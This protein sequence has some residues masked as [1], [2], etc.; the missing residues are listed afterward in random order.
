MPD[1]QMKL[2]IDE[3]QDVPVPQEVS[4]IFNGTQDPNDSMSELDEQMDLPDEMEKVETLQSV[5]H[6]QLKASTIRKQW[7]T[8]MV[9]QKNQGDEG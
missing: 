5:I 1:N 8:P 6:P 3:S 7:K 2:K 4:D 9:H